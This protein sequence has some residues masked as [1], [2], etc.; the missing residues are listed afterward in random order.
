MQLR[1]FG[2]ACL[3]VLD[4]DDV[5]L[6]TDPWLVGSVYW[7]SWWLERYPEPA[8]IGLVSSARYIYITHSHPDHFHWPTLRRLGPRRTLHPAFPSY[9]VPGFLR[10]HGFSAVVLDPWR[11]YA[12]DDRVRIASVPVP[13][14]DSILV[15][16]TPSATIVN[17]N[18]SV[19][20]KWVLRRIR[21]ELCDPMVPTIA[22]RSYSP[23]SLS[24]SMFREGVRVPFKSKEDY[25]EVAQQVSESLGASHFIPFA[26]QA[27]YWRSDSRWANDFKVTFGDLQRLW[28]STVVLLPPHLD[29]DLETKD[30]RVTEELPTPTGPTP[31]Q[32][33]KI[34]EREAHE[35]SFVFPD[36]SI[37]MLRSYMGSMR[38]VRV[39]YPRGIVW[40]LAT[41]GRSLRF[42]PRTGGIT[43][44]RV[45]RWDLKI[46]VP[47]AVLHE[48]LVNGILTDLGI[49]MF[50]RLDTRVSARR[51][52]AFFLLMGLRDYGHLRGPRA[53]YRLIRFYASEVVPLN[54]CRARRRPASYVERL[55]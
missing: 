45:D 9:P 43:E 54:V 52:Y 39:L 55:R 21:E 48:G 18:D 38:F 22:L 29:I 46:T 2:H 16:S 42:D 12:I 40:Q 6:A 10:Q 51:A 53:L 26:S 3:V 44:D 25:V 11:W 49:T 17:V 28:T 13:I 19:P 50:V 33:A 30:V 8:E 23:A 4:G 47:D 15:V 37:E 35:A 41:S 24:A 31:S 32:A 1:T 27:L 7:R 14:D 20:R 5:L 34:S 36:Q